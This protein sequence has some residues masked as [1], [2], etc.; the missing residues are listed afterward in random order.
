MVVH[1]ESWIIFMKIHVVKTQISKF[2]IC[3]VS[4]KFMD[5]LV[6]EKCCVLTMWKF[7]D[8]H[9][10]QS[11]ATNGNELFVWAVPFSSLDQGKFDEKTFWGVGWGYRSTMTQNGTRMHKLGPLKPKFLWGRTPRPPCKK[12]YCLGVYKHPCPHA[13]SMLYAF[14]DETHFDPR[15]IYIV[16]IT[17]L[18]ESKFIKNCGVRS[19]VKSPQ[20]HLFPPKWPKIYKK[21]PKIGQ[22]WPKILWPKIGFPAGRPGPAKIKK[23]ILIFRPFQSMAF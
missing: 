6:Y 12:M 2:G 15:Y 8:F 20:C 5:R 19:P 7:I 18:A 14:Q 22:K 16:S 17:T 1:R 3:S 4:S 13:S 23:K 21:W 10:N 9:V 11:L